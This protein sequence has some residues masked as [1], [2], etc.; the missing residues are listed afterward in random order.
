MTRFLPP[1]RRFHAIFFFFSLSSV[2]SIIIFFA[3]F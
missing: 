1:F 3:E 2:S